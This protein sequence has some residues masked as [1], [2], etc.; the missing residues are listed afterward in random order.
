[1]LRVSAGHDPTSH[2][3]PRSLRYEFAEDEWIAIRPRGYP[4]EHALRTTLDGMIKNLL[5]FTQSRRVYFYL[6]VIA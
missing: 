1:M 3:Q 6:N 5:L 4:E 2:T